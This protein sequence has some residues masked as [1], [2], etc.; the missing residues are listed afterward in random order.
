MCSLVLHWVLLITTLSVVGFGLSNLYRSKILKVLS[1]WSRA[2]RSFILNTILKSADPIEAFD[3]AIGEVVGR[4]VPTTVCIVDLKT[5]NGLMPGAG[6]LMMLRRLHVMP[7]V[8]HA[9][10]IIGTDLCLLML[11]P[12]RSMVL[13]GSHIMNTP[14]ILWCTPPVHTS[15][16]RHLKARSLV[17]SHLFLLSGGLEV[18]WWCSCREIVSPGPS[19]WS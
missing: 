11:R 4:L 13:L 14:G 8:E 17:W 10:N 16:G 19:V 3:R 5:S 12:R 2:V 15:G 7:G 9:E 1:F 18:V 6:E